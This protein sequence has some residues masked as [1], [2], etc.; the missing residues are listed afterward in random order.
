[1]KNII[2]L[3]LLPF[4]SQAQTFY[5]KEI[6]KPIYNTLKNRISYLGYSVTEDKKEADFIAE[7]VY[8]K[9]KG[10]MSFKS[11]YNKVGFIRFLD[12]GGTELYKTKEQ[13]GIARGYNTYSALSSLFKKIMKEDFDSTLKKAVAS[14]TPA[15]KEH[16][17]RSTSKVDELAKLKKLLD[18][19]A[20]TKEEFEAEKK[21]LLK[22]PQ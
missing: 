9:K 12:S 10:Y 2:P 17:Q 1:M 18:E 13:G 20:L 15:K 8:E 7:L 14:Y 5:I 21:K 6:D 11:G 16:F 3:L 4:F 19:G 22:L